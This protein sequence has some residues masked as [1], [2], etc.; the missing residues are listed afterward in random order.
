MA[1]VQ[2][3]GA[4]DGYTQQMDNS[5]FF[6]NSRFSEDTTN[7]GFGAAF[8]FCTGDIVLWVLLI[9]LTIGSYRN[10][11]LM[12]IFGGFSIDLNHGFW[13]WFGVFG[14]FCSK[15]SSCLVGIGKFSRNPSSEKSEKII[16][17]SAEISEEINE[18]S[19][20]ISEEG[21]N[22]GDED[23]EMGTIEELKKAIEIEKEE[24][25]RAITELENERMS[26]TCATNEAMDMIL[27]LQSEKSSIQI[28]ANQSKRLAE[29][30]QQYDQEIIQSLQWVIFKHESER[31]VLENQLKLCKLKLRECLKL[32]ELEQFEEELLNSAN[33]EEDGAST[34]SRDTDS[35]SM[36]YFGVMW[37]KNK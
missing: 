31:S 6:R 29:Q 35:S 2:T 28:E 30:K 24:K 23:E 17:K 8:T 19:V 36:I 33:V 4:I 27:R 12:R 22:D 32:D 3:L 13:L 18:K 16:E 15:I 21:K 11:G 20:E 25:N 10:K 37:C 7:S 9:L 26:S 34:G 14:L 5:S 1:E